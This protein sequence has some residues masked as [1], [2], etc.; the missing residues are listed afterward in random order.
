MNT[1]RAFCSALVLGAALAAQNPATAVPYGSGCIGLTLAS[2]LPQFAVPWNLTTDGFVP[3]TLIVIGFSTA[4]ASVPLPSPPWAPGCTLLIAPPIIAYV[5]PAVAPPA[6]FSVPVPNTASLKG[7]VLYV[8]SFGIPPGFWSASNG[9]MA[10][11]G[12]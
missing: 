3:G 1:L 9:I 11:I 7:A 12:T 2:S 5:V 4:P 8:Q 6:V 10:T